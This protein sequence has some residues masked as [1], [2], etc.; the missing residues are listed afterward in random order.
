MRKYINEQVIKK[1]SAINDIII[2]WP[3]PK[4][5]EILG[6]TSL[7]Y[8]EKVIFPLKV[9]LNNK[10]K[11]TNINLN[12]NYLVCKNICIP[13]NANLFIELPCGYGQYTEF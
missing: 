8:D 4:E 7:G 9:K 1:I 13:A 2:D 6:L 11:V 10:N 3:V 5:F 12:I